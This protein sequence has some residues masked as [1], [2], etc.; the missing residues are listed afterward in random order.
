MTQKVFLLVKLVARE[1]VIIALATGAILLATRLV[2]KVGT[3]N[4]LEAGGAKPLVEVGTEMH[5]NDVDMRGEHGSLLLVSSEQCGFCQ[6]SKP[7][8]ERLFDAAHRHGVT[9]R[10]AVPDTK[11]ASSYIKGFRTASTL[12]WKKL[13]VSILGT[14][15]LLAV[16]SKGVITHIWVGALPAEKEAE[17]VRIVENVGELET[18][19]GIIAS[20]LSAVPDYSL[21]KIQR[22]WDANTY[23][24]VDT[25][26]RGM[27]QS[28]S[29]ERINIP[30]S[31]LAIRAQ[32]ELDKERLQL[33]DCSKVNIGK[34]RT[35]IVRLQGLGYRVATAGM[36][37]YF[38]SCSAEL[39]GTR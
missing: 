35:S 31:E 32:F 17:I 9:T 33:I 34:C 18:V 36:G 37:A 24:L 14:P 38:Q 20:G 29:D 8:H 15:T 19:D 25:R 1:V 23:Q 4:D 13:N 10:V 6:K 28:P 7:F 2:G 21:T 3:H 26:E 22:E 12:E 11:K 27:R 30:L 5:I 16:S 39:V